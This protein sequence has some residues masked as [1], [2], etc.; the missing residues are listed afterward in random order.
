MQDH[1]VLDTDKV[2]RL[3]MKLTVPIFLGMTVQAVYNAVDTIFIGKFVVNPELAMA[4]LSISFPFQM[5]TM[6]VGQ[7]VG[8][9]GASLISRM[10]GRGDKPGAEHTLGN[11]I[12]FGVVLS[13][14]LMAGFLPFLNFWLRLVG[15]SDAV[16]PYARDY[17]S[18]MM[19]GA[20]FNVMSNAVISFVRAEGNARVAMTGMIVASL[21][22]ILL[23]W[24]FIVRLQ[25]GTRGAALSTMIS[26]GASTAYVL[27]YYLNGNSY[28]KMRARN[29]LPNFSILKQ[30]FVIGIASFV[31]TTAGSLSASMIMRTAA[32]YGGDIAIAAFL[33]IQRVMWFSMMPSMVI[34]Q[35]MQPILGFN[36]GAKRYNLVVK[37]IT[38][39]SF[40]AIGVGILGFFVLYFFPQPIFRIFT[41]DELL[42]AKGAYIAKL[43]FLGLPVFGFYNVGSMVFPSVGKALQTFIIAVAR[44]MAFMIPL[45]LL[46]PRLLGERGV[47]YS[48]PGS[49]ALTFLLVLGLLI[50][51]VKGLN[52]EHTESLLTQKSPAGV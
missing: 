26:M 22:N 27:I 47:W 11:G 50:P 1:N 31:Q 14:V 21:L 5:L 52:R 20:G 51:M 28:L 17:L 46:L 9:G 39:A 12:T 40:I 18:I 36:H 38:T 4:G 48:F 42:I 34:G 6:G 15:A 45:L 44:P 10:L 2:G 7:M 8:L 49:D 29:L 16:L 37:T 43:V 24:V 19:A 32:T 35:G 3:L 13:L 25:M 33:V 23:D 41:S 30:I